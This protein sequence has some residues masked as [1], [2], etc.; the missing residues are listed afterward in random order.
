MSH[1]L[2]QKMLTKAS[3]LFGR[4]FVSGRGQHN[5]RNCF[6]R[7]AEG[8]DW[9][10]LRDEGALVG[11][12]VEF[13]QYLLDKAQAEAAAKFRRQT[14]YVDDRLAAEIDPEL[15]AKLREPECPAD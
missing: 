14:I 7:D 5:G 8:K 15:L 2:G 3:R 4:T 1:V 9:V 6:L 13:G 12:L 11:T 10:W